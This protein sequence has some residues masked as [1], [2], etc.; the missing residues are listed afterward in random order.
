MPV[1]VLTNLGYVVGY[2]EVRRDPLWVCYRLARVA[3][4]PSS[5]RPDHF[6]TDTRTKALVT[7][8]AYTRSG[9]DRGHLAPNYGIATRYGDQAQLETFRMSNIVPQTPNLNRTVWKRLEQFEADQLAQQCEEVW[10]ITGPVFDAAIERLASGVEVP[11][12]CYKIIADED[13]GKL[14]VLAFIIPQDTPTQ[15]RIESYLTSVDEVERE[16][17]LDFLADLPDDVENQIEAQRPTT[18]W[19]S[20]N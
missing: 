6:T 16:T 17:G 5:P 10:V 15:A 19:Y 11:D 13:G 20:P 2:S 18:L 7:P 4:E 3:S 8:D 9:Y 14:R 1:T 12:A